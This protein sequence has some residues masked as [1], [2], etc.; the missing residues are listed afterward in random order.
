LRLFREQG[1]AGTTVEQIAEAAEVSPSTF[2]RYFPTK[3]DVVLYDALDPLLIEA[4]RRQ[5]PGVGPVAAMRAAM[6]EVW[7]AL[8]PAEVDEQIERGR[9]AYTVPELQGRY[10]T[11]MLR[12]GAIMAELIAERLGRRPD[13]F[14]I[15]VA[16][17][18]M[19]GA[20][21]AAILPL[22]GEGPPNDFAARMDRAIDVIE[23]G[24]R[25]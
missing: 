1:Y 12:T 23:D 14:E 13:D 5:P 22:I 11:E 25:F 10:A 20:L 4:Y 9:L 3:E 15:R 24:L 2:F 16:T 18:A 21:L 17:G 6:H 7:D 19:M 8:S